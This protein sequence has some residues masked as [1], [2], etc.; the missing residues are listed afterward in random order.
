[1][2]KGKKGIS[3]KVILEAA[4]FTLS[5]FLVIIL[6]G[7]FLPFMNSGRGVTY[8]AE[9]EM[10]RLEQSLIRA[11]RED[12]FPINYPLGIAEGVQFA[13]FGKNDNGELLIRPEFECDDKSS[14][15]C[16]CMCRDNCQQVIDCKVFDEYDSI[17][18]E[19]GGALAIK[20]EGRITNLQIEKQDKTLI[21]KVVG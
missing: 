6:F 7:S 13:G 17:K 12:A 8:A 10:E 14:Y 16:I 19:N 1:M 18:S 3:T 5:A 4:G 20:G 15:S 2:I 21:F 11:E 9:N